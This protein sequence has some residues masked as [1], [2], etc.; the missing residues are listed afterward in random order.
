MRA[1][2]FKQ[3]GYSMLHATSGIEYYPSVA[4]GSR[5]SATPPRTQVHHSQSESSS[6]SVEVTAFEPLVP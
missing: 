1:A 6:S 4:R 2:D 3:T 5:I